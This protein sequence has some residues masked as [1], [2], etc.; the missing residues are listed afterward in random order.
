MVPWGMYLEKEAA[1]VPGPVPQ[2]RSFKEGLVLAM[3]WRVGIR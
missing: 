1:I 2:S 3:D